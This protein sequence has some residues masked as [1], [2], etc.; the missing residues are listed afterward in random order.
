MAVAA[1]DTIAGAILDAAVAGLAVA[2][3]GRAAPGTSYVSHGPPTGEHCCDDGYLTVHLDRLETAPSLDGDFPQ[4]PCA[5]LPYAHYIITLGRCV[6]QLGDSMTTTSVP[7]ADLD[8][9]AA[10]LLE[11]LWALWTELADRIKAG[12]LVD[13]TACR[14]VRLGEALPLEESGACAGW[15]IAL[16]VLVNDAGPTGS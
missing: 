13:G 9:A 11:D 14:D 6:P 12:T 4:V 3:T 1:L 10:D 8:A 16:R 15:V 5:L 2:T 7:A